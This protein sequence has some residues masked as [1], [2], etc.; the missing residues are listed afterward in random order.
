MKG[1]TM[2][3]TIKNACL[4][5]MFALFSLVFVTNA[6][7]MTL[8][9]ITVNQLD[10]VGGI[11]G[12]GFAVSTSNLTLYDASG[13]LLFGAG[14]PS[15]NLDM[16]PGNYSIFYTTD[17]IGWP[18]LPDNHDINSVVGLYFNGNPQRLDPDLAG[19]AAYDVVNSPLGAYTGTHSQPSSLLYSDGTEQVNLTGFDNSIAEHFNQL[20]EL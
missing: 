11:S 9:N 4:T 18:Q 12:A 8:T 6:S 15:F 17:Y 5:G 10:S 2:K 1:K 3:K 16:T 20:A 19:T 14:K 7:A 13:A